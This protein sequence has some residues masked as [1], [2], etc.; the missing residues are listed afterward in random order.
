MIETKPSVSFG[1]ALLHDEH[2]S[3]RAKIIELAKELTQPLRVDTVLARFADPAQTTAPEP[4]TWLLFDFHRLFLY[5]DPGLP[6]KPN[7]ASVV[8]FIID[9]YPFEQFELLAGY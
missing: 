1:Q 3:L 5:N 4:Q 8:Q 9:F 2:S 6:D 7:I